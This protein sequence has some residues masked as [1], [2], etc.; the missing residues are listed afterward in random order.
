MDNMKIMK[1]IFK[2]HPLTY[3]LI[4]ISI[5]SGRFKIISLY[6]LIIIFHELGHLSMGVLFNW[7][8]DKIYIYPLGGLTKFNDLINRPLIEE[9]LVTIMGPIFQII[10]TCFLKKYDQNIV[11]FSNTLLVFNLLPIVPLDGGKL[12]N[13]LLYSFSPIKKSIDIAIKISYFFYILLFINIL[14]TKSM[15]FIFIFFLLIFKIHE[16]SKRKKY[17]LDKYILEKYLYTIK[18]KSNII[19]NNIKKVYKY[20]N[21]YI[22]LNNKLYSEKEYLEILN[23][24]KQL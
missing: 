1:N 15:F 21:N 6:M 24:K 4:I 8:V 3:L 7:K 19:I 2:I 23:N 18:Y 14:N 5:L 10:I 9:L 11:L 16:E 20:K 13:I 12:L 17:Y 22:K